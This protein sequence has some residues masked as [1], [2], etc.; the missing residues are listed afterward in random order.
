MDQPTTCAR[1]RRPGLSIL[2]SIRDH[3]PFL[4]TQERVMVAYLGGV[5]AGLARALP[6]PPSAEAPPAPRYAEPASA[7]PVIAADRAVA[8]RGAGGAAAGPPPARRPRPSRR[9]GTA[10]A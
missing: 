7:T 10:P 1:R 2:P 6:R 3:G 5:G 8:G 9:N 4:E